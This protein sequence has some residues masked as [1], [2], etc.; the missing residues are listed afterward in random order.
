MPYSFVIMSDNDGSNFENYL[1]WLSEYPIDDLELIVVESAEGTKSAEETEAAFAKFKKGL[2]KF[3]KIT[4]EVVVPPE[5]A[6]YSDALNLGVAKASSQ[7][8]FITNP[9]TLV[10]HDWH[11]WLNRHLE[12]DN[13]DIVAPLLNDSV[14]SQDLAQA[15]QVVGADYSKMKQAVDYFA[16]VNGFFTGRIREA[17]YVET[18]AL[19]CS[20]E[21]LKQI[22]PLPAGLRSAE[23]TAL[24][25]CKS[26]KKAGL[27]IGVAEDVFLFKAL[28]GPQR[29][30]EEHLSLIEQDLTTLAK[31]M[32][33]SGETSNEDELRTELS[34]AG[35]KVS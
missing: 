4:L 10:F 34:S 28:P 19:F 22:F 17:G 6:S 1:M 7:V 15:L 2:G 27:K 9:R 11:R 12:K 18:Y 20:T 8:T 14:P 24:A 29:T 26:A 5:H 13:Y 30:L 25:L 23:V 33:A 31:A 35:L 21:K 16:F 32:S 3:K